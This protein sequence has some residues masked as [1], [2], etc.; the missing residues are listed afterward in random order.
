[1]VFK[2]KISAEASAFVCVAKKLRGV[3]AKEILQEAHI[4]RASLY[5]ILK[6][7]EPKRNDHVV[8]RRKACGRPRKLCDREERLLLRDI[9]RLRKEE[10]QFTVRRLIQQAGISP[11]DI[12]IRTVQRFLRRHGYKYLQARQ[13]GLLTEQDLKK[14]L[15]FHAR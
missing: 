4:S 5:R 13:K 15:Q 14:R 7:G 9:P 11:R 10:G 12:S 2:A 8:W 6:R 3:R 1:M